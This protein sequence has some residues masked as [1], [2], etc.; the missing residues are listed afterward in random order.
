MTDSYFFSEVTLSPFPSTQETALET[1]PVESTE[2]SLYDPVLGCEYPSLRSSYKAEEKDGSFM[3]MEI[4]RLWISDDIRW[5]GYRWMESVVKGESLLWIFPHQ[6]SSTSLRLDRFGLKLAPS[7]HQQVFDSVDMLVKG[8]LKELDVVSLGG[9]LS[10]CD[11][12]FRC[13]TFSLFISFHT[14]NLNTVHQS[15]EQ[16]KV[17]SSNVNI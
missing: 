2:A 12:N 17:P 15:Y 10:Y 11:F 13:T 1:H 3:E 6:T 5:Y 9:T 14:L 4:C 8:L 7:E 16:T